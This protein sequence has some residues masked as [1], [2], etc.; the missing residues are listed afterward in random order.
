MKKLLIF[1]TLL[2]IMFSACEGPMGPAGPMGPQGQPG[3]ESYWYT[4][5]F[6]V[7]SSAWRL[8]G[9]PDELNSYFYY[10]KAVPQLTNNIFNGGIV[11]LYLQAANNIKN[12]MPYVLHLGDEDH[13][14]EFFWTQTY[15]YDFEQG[16]IR[17][18]VTYS[19]FMTSRRPDTETFS[20]ILL[21]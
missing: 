10:D 18:Y 14:G 9:Q 2:A 4:T 11:L 15:D 21:Y 19:D 20:L 1:T 6:T 5:S 17:I 3:D 7:N 8:E 13:L 12:V 16:N